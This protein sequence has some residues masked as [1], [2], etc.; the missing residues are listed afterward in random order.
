MSGVAVREWL[1]S[2]R[3]K[4]GGGFVGYGEEHAWTQKSG[5]WRLPYMDDLLLPHNIDMM[6]SEKNSGVCTTALDG[7]EYYGIIEEI[8]ELTFHGCKPL[9]PVIFKFHWFDPNEV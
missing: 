1:Q 4:E 7:V 8:Y 6:H 9:K 2:L 3:V 5:L